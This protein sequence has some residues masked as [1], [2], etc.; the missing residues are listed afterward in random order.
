[1]PLGEAFHTVFAESYGPAAYERMRSFG[2]VT[3]LASHDEASLIQAVGE[4]DALLVRS[5]SQVTRTVLEAAHRLRVI[6]RGGVGIDNIDVAAAKEKG[7]AV[8]YTPEASTEAVA[9]LTIGLM[10][11]LVRRIHEGDHLIREGRFEDGRRSCLGCELGALTLGIVGMG[12]IGKAVARR[13]RHGF[14]MNILYNDIVDVGP[15]DIDATAVPKPELFQAADVVSLHVP[16]TADTRNLINT[17]ALRNSRR[18][19]LLINTA[20]GAVVD[21]QSLAESLASGHLGGAALDVTEPE[22]LPIGHPLF[23]TPNTLLT[24]HIAARTTESMHRMDMVVEDVI[25]V[26]QGEVPRFATTDM[27][28]A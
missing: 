27:T 6:G 11:S 2:R 13:S 5:Y 24:P 4:C 16:L 26:L 23:L 21:S 15:L 10:I 8:V 9:D 28:T 14:G 18:G 12:R 17:G 25:R 1:M 20:R 3:R 22:P 19:S 7:I